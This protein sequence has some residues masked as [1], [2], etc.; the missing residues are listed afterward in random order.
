MAFPTDLDERS[1][2]LPGNQVGDFYRNI[3]KDIK[4][5]GE[6]TTSRALK[7]LSWIRYAKSSLEERMLPEAIGE[8]LK[9]ESILR[10]CMSLVILSEKRRCWRFSHTTTVTEFLDNR[11]SLEDMGIKLLTPI[12]LAKRC[13]DYLDS[14]EFE[15]MEIKTDSRRIGTSDILRRYGFGG[16]AARFWASHVRD[17]EDDFLSGGF[18]CLS[19]FKFLV[20]KQKRH[21]MLKLNHQS[22]T[23]TILH[24]AAAKGLTNFCSL[25]FGAK[26]A[27]VAQEALTN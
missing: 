16:Y 1:K 4:T 8:P 26:A 3:M 15:S 11:G 6:P 7:A 18:E 14:S 17:V 21:S 25:C 23:S 5:L 2:V 9:V 20:S 24:F 10:P 12:D 13:L 22:R 27:S 19:Y